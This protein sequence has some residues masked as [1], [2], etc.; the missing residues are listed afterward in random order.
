MKLLLSLLHVSVL[1]LLV[2]IEA[3]ACAL[4]DSSVVYF[5][6]FSTQTFLP[7]L[8]KDF[9]GGKQGGKMVIKNA[10]FKKLLENSKLDTNEPFSENIRM[11]VNFDEQIYYINDQGDIQFK[12]SVIGKLDKETRDYLDKG[13]DLYEWKTCRPMNEVLT[14]MLEKHNKHVEKLFKEQNRK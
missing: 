4:P 9:Q 11:T 1:F 3:K 8:K 14:K 5:K 7:V 6:L 13:Y 10:Y 2:I 12:N